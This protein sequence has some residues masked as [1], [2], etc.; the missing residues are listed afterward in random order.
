MAGRA[1]D[2]PQA[3]LDA[4]STPSR[5]GESAGRQLQRGLGLAVKGDRAVPGDSGKEGLHPVTG[6]AVTAQRRRI[7]FGR[8]WPL[9]DEY[10]PFPGWAFQPEPEDNT[11]T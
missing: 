11:P 3:P 2:T 9:Q 10:T 6:Q 8:T 1:G 4:Q 7:H 5:T